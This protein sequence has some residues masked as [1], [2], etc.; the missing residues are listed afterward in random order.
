MNNQLI[1]LGEIMGGFS[2]HNLKSILLEYLL[3][4]KVY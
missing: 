4:L 3:I 1:L 2:S